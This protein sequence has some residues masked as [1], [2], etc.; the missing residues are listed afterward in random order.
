[1]TAPTPTLFNTGKRHAADEPV[2]TGPF[3]GLFADIVFDR[4]LDHAFTYA[5]PN[6]LVA[7]GYLRKEDVAP[8]VEQAGGRWDFVFSRR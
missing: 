6:D 4:P 5:I 3:S 7:K 8:V 1:M 2:P